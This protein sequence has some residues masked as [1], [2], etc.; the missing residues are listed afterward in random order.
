MTRAAETLS[1]Q[2]RE[3]PMVKIEKKYTFEGPKGAISLDELFQGHKQLIIYHFMFRP[4]ADEG[5]SSC[6]FF[7]D[8]VPDLRHLASRDTSFAVISRAPIA[9]IEAFKKR[10]GWTFPW[11]SS[12]GSDFNY[13]FHVA[14][15]ETVAPVQYNYMDKETL[16]K[17]G[18][19]HFTR[20][21]QHGMSV[22]LRENDD[23]FHT[24]SSYS[25]G[26]DKFLSTYHMLDITPLGRQD[27]KKLGLGFTYHDQYDKI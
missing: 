24:Y 23:I 19:A 14:Q 6:S 11:Y 13:D 2:V 22:F 10:M 8:H 21:E 25:R 17:R 3:L 18:L 27:S 5:C 9:K 15:D 16:E 12:F 7:A 4:E 26:L 1:A 20:G